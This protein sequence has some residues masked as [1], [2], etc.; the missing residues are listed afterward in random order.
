MEKKEP[1]ASLPAPSGFFRECRSLMHAAGRS[2]GGVVAARERDFLSLGERLHHLRSKSEELA[3][4]AAALAATTSG[5]SMDEVLGN[6]S[7]EL[8][9]MTGVCEM[10]NSRESLEELTSVRGIVAD[11]E[12][13]SSEFGRIVK[14]LSMLGISTRIESARLGTQGLGFSTLS[15]D[16]EKLA[17]NIIGYAGQINERNRALRGL[18]DEAEVKT[19]SVVDSQERC[20]SVIFG[21]LHEN[22]ETLSRL[23][24]TSAAL[25]ETISDKTRTVTE[26]VSSAVLSMQFHDI[27]R[28][29][30]EHVEQAMGD[31]DQ[32]VAARF[33][34]QPLETER[35]GFG[36][37]DREVVAWIGD[38][39]DLQCSQLGNAR[40]RFV[41]A[42]ET[43]VE[44]L[45]DIAES[46]M[47]IGGE[48]LGVAGDDR[49]GA[50]LGRVAQDVAQVKDAL[51]GFAAK[52]EELAGIMSSVAG[53]ISEMS[54]Y[55][56]KI[57]DVGSEIELIA[58]N[59]SIKAAHTG[60]QGAALGVLASAIQ[61]LSVE[62]RQQ[63]DE[64][65][66][67]LRDV[68]KSSNILQ[69]NASISYDVS[70]VD[71]VSA[72]LDG[73]LGQIGDMNRKRTAMFAEIGEKSAELGEAVQGLASGVH[74][75]EEV[76]DR[77]ESVRRDLDA[78]RALSKRIVPVESD[79]RRPDR[80]REL[81]GR[82]TMEAE[83]DVHESVFGAAGMAE[84]KDNRSK[85]TPDA[86]GLGDN[87][88]LF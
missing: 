82:Y 8:E 84:K 19:K 24:A 75:H 51:R 67:I 27:V 52:G 80:L 7:T 49:S 47:S 2:L 40:E 6:L 79:V 87:V 74:F 86:G 66:R 60:E 50:D 18:V 44:N 70:R 58:I 63:T 69:D 37:E 17:A 38:V 46:I 1:G 48:V 88:E 26:N 73:L 76:G 33:A 16:V 64:V 30:V 29:Q 81:F 15:D 54:G 61:G 85:A 23:A 36:D 20:S 62:A 53:T 10:G 35:D 25:S 22:I 28:Q 78:F 31:V 55:V 83:R 43:L 72:H 32:V 45:R 14:R 77:L 9:Q 71:E 34:D 68:A 57:E 11:L 4:R 5:E 41:N 21:G 12:K 39:L 42:V 65:S 3:E 56:G 59:A 13:I